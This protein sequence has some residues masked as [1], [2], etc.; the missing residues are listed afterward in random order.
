MKSSANEPA[1]SSSISVIQTFRPE[2]SSP[3]SGSWPH[4]VICWT[5]RL[6][7]WWTPIVSAGMAVYRL[8]RG[9]GL[10]PVMNRDL[11]PTR[12]LPSANGSRDG[13]NTQSRN[14]GK[15][16][17]VPEKNL[18][19]NA[20]IPSERTLACRWPVSPQVVRTACYP[21]MPGTSCV[22]SR[23]LHDL[24]RGRWYQTRT[25]VWRDE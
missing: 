25:R 6:K 18:E 8:I 5:Q 16:G 13:P 14:G 11:V 21:L 9:I 15:S 12:C 17:H 3:V 7:Q 19:K 10:L 23:R 24:A 2:R 22:S 4:K 20:M 1:I